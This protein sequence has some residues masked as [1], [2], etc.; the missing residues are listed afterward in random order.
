MN[1]ELAIRIASTE[2]RSLSWRE[3]ENV[4][5]TYLTYLA[6]CPMCDGT[7]AASDAATCD[8]CAGSG[9]DDQ[10]LVWEC[11]SVVG[12]SRCSCGEA[13]APGCEPIVRV[14]QKGLVPTGMPLASAVDL[15]LSPEI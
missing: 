1:H 9:R 6:V 15:Q 2:V 12:G 14:P 7:G 5:R 8:R 4:I 10:N 13:G 11:A 3:A